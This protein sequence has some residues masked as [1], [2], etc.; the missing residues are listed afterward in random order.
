MLLP[1]VETADLHQI[2]IVTVCN[3]QYTCTFVSKKNSKCAKLWTN[4]AISADDLF[5]IQYDWRQEVFEQSHFGK[6]EQSVCLNV[7]KER[8]SSPGDHMDQMLS[9][10]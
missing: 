3:T 6:I 4:M 9:S 8:K 5:V 10:T 2:C 1:L 7:S